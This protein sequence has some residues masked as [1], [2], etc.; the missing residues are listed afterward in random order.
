MADLGGIKMPDFCIFAGISKSW[1]I[2]KKPTGTK[3]ANLSKKESAKFWWVVPF[4]KLRAHE[5]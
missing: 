2:S 4:R 1:V 3:K 5:Q